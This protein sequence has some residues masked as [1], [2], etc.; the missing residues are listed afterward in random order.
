VIVSPRG[1]EVELVLRERDCAGHKNVYYRD[2][3][4]VTHRRKNKFWNK[5]K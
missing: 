2:F 3:D 4:L 1:T 5:I